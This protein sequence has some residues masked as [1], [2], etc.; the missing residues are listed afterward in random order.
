MSAMQIHYER[1]NARRR[2]TVTLRGGYEASE[3]LALF[4]R[5]RVEDDWSYARLYDVRDLT[6]NPTLE[7]LRQFMKL[8]AQHRP[9]GPEA[10]LTSSPILYRL[11]CTYAA[12]GQSTLTIEVFRD[13]DEATQ[14]LAAL[15]NAD[16]D[17]T[18]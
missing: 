12:L 18:P 14:W 16:G 3:I 7:E 5:H 1:D 2:V 17:V 10:I 15:A 13:T 11:A 4:D 8:D 9:H 6:G